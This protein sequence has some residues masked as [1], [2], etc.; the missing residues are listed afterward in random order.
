[1]KVLKQQLKTLK[2][3]YNI[4]SKILIKKFIFNYLLK[5]FKITLLLSI[6]SCSYLDNKIKER[7]KINQYQLCDRWINKRISDKQ[8]IRE[9]RFYNIKELD[10]I[11]EFCKDLYPINKVKAYSKS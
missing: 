9:F 8:I 1:M 4:Q 5:I 11:L 7:D 6:V 2:V 10:V 3:M